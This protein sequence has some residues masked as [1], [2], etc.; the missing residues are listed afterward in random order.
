MKRYLFG[1]LLN[2]LFVT[3]GLAQNSQD[4][5]LPNGD[6]GAFRIEVVPCDCDSTVN[7]SISISLNRC[8]DTISLFVKTASILD[9]ADSV[10]IA[11]GVPPKLVYEIGMNES[12]WQNIYDLDYLIKDGDLQV[13]DRTFNHFYN[14]MGLTGGKTRRN[15]I[16]VGIYYLKVNYNI[17]HNWKKA[18]YAY[19]RGRWKPESEWTRLERHFMNKIDW[20]QYD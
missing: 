9:F 7:D 11:Y 14:E 1:I 17:Y 13:I 18:R 6:R 2:L 3:I 19:G 10:A 5:T 8:F 16:L 15:Y 4:T 20:N 12:R